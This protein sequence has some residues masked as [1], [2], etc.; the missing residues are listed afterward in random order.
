MMMVDGRFQTVTKGRKVLERGDCRKM[1]PV[2]GSSGEVIEDCTT[3]L[4]LPNG[5]C[6]KVRVNGVTPA[7]WHTFGDGLRGTDPSQDGQE[8][9]DRVRGQRFP[10]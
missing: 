4:P 6:R 7:E 5:G 2:A 1:A 10:Q 9:P 3:H 8:V